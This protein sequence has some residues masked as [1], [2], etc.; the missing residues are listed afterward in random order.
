M[1]FLSIAIT[2]IAITLGWVYTNRQ[3]RAMSRKQHTFNALLHASFAEGFQN[4]L[5]KV[6]PYL[7]GKEKHGGE[8]PDGSDAIGFMLDHYEFLSAGVRNGDIDEKLLRDGDRGI[9]VKL[10]EAFQKRIYASRDRPGREAVYEHLEWLYDRWKRNPPGKVQYF[11]EW[12]RG[13]PLY[14][15]R[16]PIKIPTQSN[17]S[18]LLLC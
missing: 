18:G 3:N 14:G 4:N 8:L 6:T 10:Y 17:E 5:A 12:C 11:C 2:A 15:R 9:V 1:D 7:R 13:R 16:N